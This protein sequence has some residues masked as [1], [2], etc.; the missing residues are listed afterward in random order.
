MN[1]ECVS[2]EALR[3]LFGRKYH[4]WK[5]VSK[6]SRQIQVDGW[7]LYWLGDDH[8]FDPNLKFKMSLRDVLCVREK[9]DEL[10][11]GIAESVRVIGLDEG[12]CWN[13]ERVEN[14]PSTNFPRAAD[15]LEILRNYAIDGTAIQK[16][17][18]ILFGIVRLAGLYELIAEHTPESGIR[19]LDHLYHDMNQHLSK[20]FAQ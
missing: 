19:L 2:F 12:R 16:N 18:I 5:K 17:Y 14:L 13:A 6:E 8:V 9:R 20:G 1:G 3:V 15:V 7:G 11:R 4:P 10:A